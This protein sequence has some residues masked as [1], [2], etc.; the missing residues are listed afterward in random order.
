MRKKRPEKASQAFD[1]GQAALS[2]FDWSAAAAYFKRAQTEVTNKD[3]LFGAYLNGATAEMRLA[4]FSKARLLVKKALALGIEYDQ[5]YFGAAVVEANSGA[6]LS[7]KEILERLLAVHPDDS[8]AWALM[9]FVNEQLG[10]PES[11]IQAAEHALEFEVAFDG[12]V[13]CTAARAYVAMGN[14]SRAEEL[15]AEVIQGPSHGQAVMKTTVHPVATAFAGLGQLRLIQGR[16][17]LSDSF[18]QQALNFFQKATVIDP[19]HK[20]A[21]A[22]LAELAM[23]RGSFQTAANAAVKALELLWMPDVRL[24]RIQ[25]SALS[26]LRMFKEAQQCLDQARKS[27][28]KEELVGV[29]RDEMLNF[30]RQHKWSDTVTL[31][32]ELEALQSHPDPIELNTKAGALLELG[33]SAE[34][35]QTLQLA[36]QTA[37]NDPIILVNYGF[38]RWCDAA[39]DAGRKEGLEQILKGLA[40]K[41]RYPEA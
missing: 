25:G 34:A 22:N 17:S 30:A 16:G 39:D 35:L 40:L 20:D 9:A 8:I 18:E 7:A 32:E 3:D 5:R 14:Y 23:E 12:E 21:W 15:Y 26:N 6:P 41:P 13:R 33:K 37:P 31:C 38:A 1:R 19:G 2:R 36:C 24:L 10:S 28:A 4:R 27:S 29:V 11:A